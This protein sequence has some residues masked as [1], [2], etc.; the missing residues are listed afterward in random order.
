MSFKPPFARLR[1]IHGN[2]VRAVPDDEVSI[3]QAQPVAK[4]VE[5]EPV[6]EHV[7]SE[8]DSVAVVTEE[9]PVVEAPAAEEASAEVSSEADV[10]VEPDEATIEEAPK[11]A[12]KKGKKS[13]D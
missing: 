13:A 4:V 6:V 5:P 11:K 9:A 3:P 1:E 8:P 2:I 12:T 7:V 10:T